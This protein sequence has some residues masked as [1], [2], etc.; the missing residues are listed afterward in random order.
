M[1]NKLY[2]GYLV[3]M[4]MKMPRVIISL[5]NI[6][7]D[8]MQPQIFCR[9]YKNACNVQQ[10]KRYPQKWLILSQTLRY[11][12]SAVYINYTIIIC[13]VL[14]LYHYFKLFPFCQ[15]E[16]SGSHLTSIGYQYTQS[17]ILGFFNLIHTLVLIWLLDIFFIKTYSFQIM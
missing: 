11:W 16:I 14:C 7:L 10:K 5:W 4:V 9:E 1:A 3:K 17:I 6:L 15:G 2:S 13:V 12:G 8:N